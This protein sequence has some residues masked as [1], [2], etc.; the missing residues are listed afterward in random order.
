MKISTNCPA[1]NSKEI[2]KKP[3][4]LMP[5]IADRAFGWKPLTIEKSMGLR[6]IETGN[7]CSV[8]N[9]CF[10]KDCSFLF[11][12]IRF[13][14]DEIARLYN[15][16]RGTEYIRLRES[17]EKGYSNRNE[18]LENQI[19]YLHKVDEYILSFVE[20]PKRMLDWGGD[21][22]KN[23][24][25][26]KTSSII[27]IFEVSDK[28]ECKLNPRF[29]LVGPK[30]DLVD[31][32]DLIVAMHV[33]EHVSY[34]LKDLL[35]LVTFTKKGGYIYVEVPLENIVQFRGENDDI[36]QKKHHW[37]EHINFYNYRSLLSMAKRCGLEVLDVSSLDASDSYRDFKVQRFIARKI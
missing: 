37:H 11:C 3:A 4:V 7:A 14:E 17:Y 21:E 30:D 35:K 32:Y 15:D 19:H 28:D 36:L 18:Y 2:E 5:F 23:T 26:T 25:L 13:D 24:P 6:T 20:E 1:C 29:S 31:K 27:D 12:D 10:C 8:C 16:Y 33:F 34:P 9:S 22:G